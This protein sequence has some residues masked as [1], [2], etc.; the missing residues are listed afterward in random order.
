MLGDLDAGESGRRLLV[1]A[2]TLNK[3][4][5]EHAKALVEAGKFAYDTR[6]DWSEHRPSAKAENKYIDE[7]GMDEYGKWYLGIDREKSDTT[8]GA[9]EFP[10]GDFAK[11]HRCRILAAESRAGQYKHEDIANAVSHLHDMMEAQHR[12]R[13]ARTSTG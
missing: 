8:K 7:H 9:Y 13:G 2:V 3:R 11:V 5:F 1:M 10:Y 6:D 12:S 4:A